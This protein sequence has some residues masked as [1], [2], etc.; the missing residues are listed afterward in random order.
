LG[1]DLSGPRLAILRIAWFLSNKQTRRNQLKFTNRA[2]FG[3]WH[4]A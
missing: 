4:S 2:S 1:S 3:V